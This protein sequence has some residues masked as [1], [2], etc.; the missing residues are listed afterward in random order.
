[1]G[2][3]DDGSVEGEMRRRKWPTISVVTPTY[4]SGRVLERC[5]RLVREQ[6][7]PQKKIEIVLADGGSKDSTFEIAQKYGAR[8]VKVPPEKQ[9]AE[10]N[11]GVAF[12]AARG[13]LALILDHD[14][15]L[16]H[17]GWLKEMVEPLLANSG[18]VATETCYYHYDK[19][20]NL[21]D[22]Y[23]ALFGT[24]EPLPYFL[25]KADRM[26]WGVKKWSLVGKAQDKGKYFVVEFEPDPRRIPSIGTNGCLM[27]RELVIGNAKA[28]PEYHIP[29]DVMVDVIMKGYNQFGFVK[30]SI[31]HLT[32]SQGLREFLRRRK[33]FVEQYH[34]EERAIR[35]WSVVWSG[36]EWGLVRYV[37]YS[38]TLVG[39]M[40]TA[41]KGWWRIRDVAWW[42]HPAM[43]LGTTLMYGEVVVRFKLMGLLKGR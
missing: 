23:F 6:D 15:Y 4:N 18:M 10:Y 40:W 19:S 24:S 30:N 20:Y 22:R 27:W 2:E 7:Y 36:D 17:K 41:I 25:G 34:F 26:P 39:P 21:M 35:R 32:H 8:V 1:V 16:P 31:I 13:E 33:K 12:N 28:T 9:H 11:R 42:V 29:M 43:C 14:N 38:L 5:L 3:T 37:V